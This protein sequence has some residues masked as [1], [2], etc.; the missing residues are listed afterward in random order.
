MEQ[1]RQF[2][3]DIFPVGC[4]VNIITAAADRAVMHR[5]VSHDISKSTLDRSTDDD[6]P[7]A[8]FWTTSKTCVVV[9]EQD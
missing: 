4:R 3:N 8:T 9:F 5:I 6:T 1:E 7:D 2:T